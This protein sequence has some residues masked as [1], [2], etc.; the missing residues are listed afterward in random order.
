MKKETNELI[1]IIAEHNAVSRKANNFLKTLDTQQGIYNALD[2]I[3]DVYVSKRGNT[4]YRT[5][6][7]KYFFEDLDDAVNQLKEAYRCK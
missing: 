2:I 5:E 1:E 7:I 4:L 3:M 6:P